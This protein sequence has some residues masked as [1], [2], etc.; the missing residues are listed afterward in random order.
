MRY[1]TL[2]RLSLFA[3]LL[4]LPVQWQPRTAG[5]A[6]QK[7]NQWALLVGVN[8][9]PGEIQD[10]R[11][12]RNDARSVKDLLIS[13]A[14]FAE[15][16]IKLLTDDGVGETRATKANIFA[17][18]DQYLATR[19][20]PGHQ[21]IVFFAG[22]GIAQGLG[23]EAR[24]YFLPVDVEAQT[25]ESLTRTAIDLEDL[26]RKLST[27]KA[28]QFTVFVDAC[29]EDP[30]PGRGLKG[31][32]MTDVMA[33]GLRIVRVNTTPQAPLAAPPTSVVFY[34]CRIG[35]RAYENPELQHG[36]F[37]YYILRGIRELAARPA[38]GVEAGQ[39]AGYL[40]TNVRKWGGGIWGTRQA[41][42]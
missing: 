11:F 16:H 30:F 18:I 24:S 1:M 13:S 14:G 21:V 25:K 15:D 19:V 3:A 37:T 36:I 5:A 39:L 28:S 42:H 40:S 7:A 27:L 12:A 2:L 35:E 10:L 38:G 9:Y 34:S 29:R 22:H 4:L 41:A 32:T 33:R 26:G 17:A 23:Q 6:A 31:N 20:Q 8:D